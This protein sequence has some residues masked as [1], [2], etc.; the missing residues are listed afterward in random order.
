MT[1]KQVTGIVIIFLLTLVVSLLINLPVRQLLRFVEIPPPL[2]IQGL[3]GTI[4]SG[5]IERLSY[6]KFTI[7]EVIY[8]F[9]PAC[10][11]K[12]VVCYQFTADERELRLNLEVNP[13]TRKVSASQSSITL[14]SEILNDFPQL[15]VKPKGDFAVLVDQLTISENGMSELDA[16]LD[17]LGAG[18]QGEEQ[19][20]GNYRAVIAM[21]N[22]GFNINLS[23]MDSLLGLKGDIK[24]EW[25][26]GYNINLKF[27][28][29]PTLNQSVI[30]VLS[31][32]TARQGLNRFNLNRNGKLDAS[33]Q[34]LLNRLK[35]AI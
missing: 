20:L 10:L 17:W 28:A 4:T 31:M 34:Q 24:L 29:K 6:Q 11:F 32:A 30:S 21:Q 23:D 1:R 9:Q 27:E 14:E 15:L 33:G 25:T 16:S 19:L 12:A 13:I 5:K 35:P 18:V 2:Q 7:A 3:S 8:D 22:D 26:G